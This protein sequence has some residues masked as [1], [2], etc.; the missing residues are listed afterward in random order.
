MSIKTFAAVAAVLMGTFTVQVQ[1]GEDSLAGVSAGMNIIDIGGHPVPVQSG[2]LYDRYRSNTPLE[3]VAAEHP[4]VDLSW[5]K[6]LKKTRVDI[7]FD[8]WSPN[9]Y[10]QNSRITAVFTADLDRLRSLMPA[11]VLQQVQPL[12]VWPGR[13]LVALTAYSYFYCDNDSYNEIALSIVTSKPGSMNLGPV[14]L[15]GQNM[16]KEFWGYVLKLPVDT[17]LARVRGVVGYNLPKWLTTITL[18]ETPES[19]KYEI[20]DSVTGKVDVVIDT[21]KLADMSDEPELSTSRFTNLDQH[22]QLTTGYAVA[23]QL[24]YGSSTDADAVK[25]T[26]SDGSLSA[27]MKSLK[28]G[29][30]M[31]YEYVPDFQIALYAPVPLATYLAAE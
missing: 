18:S 19:V 25:L 3:V 31:K 24:R 16:D 11:D 13:G 2:G 27:Y 5:F 23:R 8:S 26:L 9:F 6:T 22:G 7:G 29:K 15:I 10:Y 21:Q 14:S 1:A 20:Y 17:E 12:Q 28:L 4:D 30:L